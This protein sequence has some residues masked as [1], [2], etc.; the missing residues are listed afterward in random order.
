MD[1]GPTLPVAADRV[2]LVGDI[3]LDA[4]GTPI[5][6]GPAQRIQGREGALVLVNGQHQPLIPA[7]P[8][9]SQRWRIV[10]TCVARVLS[11]R[12]QGHPLAQIAQDGTYL[13]A[14]TRRDRLVLP[15]GARADVLVTPAGTGRFALVTDRYDRGTMA[16]MGGG[17][18]ATGP[19]TLATLVCSGAPAPTPTLP[20]TL[21]A[22]P[23]PPPATAERTITFQMGMGGMGG[24]M[25]M[26]F[27]IDGRSFD[28][29]RTDQT[30]TEGSTED[31][32]LRNTG[33][34]AHPFHL[35]A[36]PF[37]VLATSDA[38]PLSGVP[39]DVVLVPPDGWARIRIPFTHHTGRSVY[40]CHILDH[41][42][43]GM[44]ATVDVQPPSP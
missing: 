30:V 38:A 21:P 12:L 8:Q 34:L 10:N 6:A 43:L 4:S 22:E 31:W 11:L 5:P 39:Q 3:T 19:I 15:P 42:D 32:T 26:A 17:T 2:L 20:D 28:P 14:P 23:S 40:H 7:V 33:P 18:P 41:E 44:M 36:W 16:M 27:T 37:T 13:R 29:T 24:G 9:A 1:D 25:G 35:H